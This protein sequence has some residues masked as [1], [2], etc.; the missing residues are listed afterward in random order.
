MAD[1]PAAAGEG[2][3][4]STA[5]AGEHQPE[6][7]TTVGDDVIKNTEGEGGARIISMT[8]LKLRPKNIAKP[9][10]PL[11]PKNTEGEVGAEA[12]AAT[13]FPRGSVGVFIEERNKRQRLHPEEQ[14][15]TVNR[16]V[17]SVPVREAAASASSPSSASSVPEVA[18]WRTNHGGTKLQFL[19][20][21]GTVRTFL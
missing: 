3:G 6:L 9:P 14:N 15:S 11:R 18:A 17:C 12:R 7:T 1:G 16:F 4:P 5:A 20:R 13:R 8:V 2:A 21:D 10:P 19:L